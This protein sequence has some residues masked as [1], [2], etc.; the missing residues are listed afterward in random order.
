MT[1]VLSADLQPHHFLQRRTGDQSP[2]PLPGEVYAWIL[3]THRRFRTVPSIDLLRQVHPLFE[4]S[5][6]TDAISALLEEMLKLVNRRC[7]IDYVRH[8]SEIAD[9]P[10]R[11]LDAPKHAFE[12]ARTFAQAVPGSKTVKLSDALT[13]LDLYNELERTGQTPGISF[14]IQWLD[15][16]TYGIQPHEMMIIEAFLGLGKSSWAARICSDAYFLRDQTPLFFSFEMDAHKLVQRWV[17]AAAKFE[18]TAIK[19][20]GLSEDDKR[21]WHDIGERATAANFEKDV[22]VI[23]DERHPTDDFIYGQIEKWTPSFSIIDTIDEVRAPTTIRGS[24]WEKVDHVARELKGIARTTK[25]PIIAIAQAGRSAAQD[26][27][28]IENIAGSLTIARKADLAV[29][30]HATEEMM[31]NHMIEF[32]LLKV[33]DDGGKGTKRTMFFDPSDLTLRPWLP[34]DSVPVK[35]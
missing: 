12:G 15:D 10:S 11:L 33:R 22:I 26:G 34:S 13:M 3:Q 18:Y 25:R 8:L 21:R 32:T 4:V 29:G 35:S 27:A 2:E 6:S 24:A 20:M 19:R 1:E 9:D 7:L 23:D 16:M 30:M 31:R 28:T 5:E 17:A 14:A